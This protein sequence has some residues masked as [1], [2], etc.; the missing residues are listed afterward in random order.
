ME[1]Y[2]EGN[3]DQDLLG[4]EENGTPDLLTVV[5]CAQRLID[6]NERLLSEGRKETQDLKEAL[7]KIQKKTG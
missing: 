7:A 2:E 3:S 4:N 6:A 5:S 1:F